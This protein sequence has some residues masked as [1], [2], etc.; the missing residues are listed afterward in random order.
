MRGGGGGKLNHSPKLETSLKVLVSGIGQ[1]RVDIVGVAL[2]SICGVSL[3]AQTMNA[4]TRARSDVQGKSS[5]CAV[6]YA[7]AAASKGAKVLRAEEVGSREG[8]SMLRLIE[9]EKGS[10][11]ST[12]ITQDLLEGPDK[13]AM[14]R[15]ELSVLV[16]VRSIQLM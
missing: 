6:S 1:A 4:I 8:A 2:S 3:A 10:V 5:E 15:Q 12:L 11:K 14:P 16:Y 9:P 7:M 13:I